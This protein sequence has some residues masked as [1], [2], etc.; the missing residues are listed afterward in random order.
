VKALEAALNDM[1]NHG[2]GLSFANLHDEL[3]LFYTKGH[4]DPSHTKDFVVDEPWFD[5]PLHVS[6]D[7]AEVILLDSVGTHYE[8]Y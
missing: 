8:V 6:L 2:L 4:F 7:E 5:A 3:T 1:A